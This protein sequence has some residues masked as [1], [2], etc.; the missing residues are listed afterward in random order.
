MKSSTPT[1][2]KPKPLENSQQM[3]EE[4]NKRVMNLFY[5][6]FSTPAV[7]EITNFPPIQEAPPVEGATTKPKIEFHSGVCDYKLRRRVQNSVFQTNGVLVQ[8][9]ETVERQPDIKNIQTINAEEVFMPDQV[10]RK[11]KPLYIQNQEEDE[12]FYDQF[13][14]HVYHPL[15]MAETEKEYRRRLKK[16]GEIGKQRCMRRYRFIKKAEK[17][18]YDFIASIN[19][20]Q[21]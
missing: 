17:Q 14:H 4:F 19:K 8:L 10:P 1:K 16:A 15:N 2:T 7:D 5:S 12:K 9:G 21:K 6:M 3:Q 20:R 18:H 13:R 11:Q